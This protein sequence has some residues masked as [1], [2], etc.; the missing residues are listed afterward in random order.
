MGNR[1]TT[2]PKSFL[3][4]EDIFLL[5]E[6]DTIAPKVRKTTR[7]NDPKNPQIDRQCPVTQHSLPEKLKA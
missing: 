7:P 4:I 6:Q 3:W 5:K 2:N 1:I